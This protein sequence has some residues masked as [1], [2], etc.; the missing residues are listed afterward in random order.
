MQDLQNLFGQIYRRVNVA[1]TALSDIDTIAARISLDDDSQ[2]QARLDA[3]DAKF[4]ALY[5][6]VGL[7]PQCIDECANVRAL[8]GLPLRGGSR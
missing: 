5:L 7:S 8:I 6:T 1:K 4:T 3:L 2:L